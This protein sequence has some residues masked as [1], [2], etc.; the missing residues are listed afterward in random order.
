ML[1]PG[2][3]PTNP[4]TTSMAEF[5][6][7]TGI[8]PDHPSFAQLFIAHMTASSAALTSNSPSVPNV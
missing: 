2:V 4:F 8:R 5:T 3:P 7:S 1:P 6:A